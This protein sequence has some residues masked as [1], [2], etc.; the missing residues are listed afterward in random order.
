MTVPNIPS[1]Y[2]KFKYN[3]LINLLLIYICTYNAEFLIIHILCNK[4]FLLLVYVEIFQHKSR[5]LTSANHRTFKIFNSNKSLRKFIEILTITITSSFF[6]TISKI[7]QKSIF[8]YSVKI[9]GCYQLERKGRLEIFLPTY[10]SSACSFISCRK[11]AT[12][13]ARAFSWLGRI[14]DH[15]VSRREIH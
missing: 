3:H 4:M 12:L 1:I 7:Y 9:R 10:S 14:S 6:Q 11:R 15:L 8:Q 2:S 13:G 5:S